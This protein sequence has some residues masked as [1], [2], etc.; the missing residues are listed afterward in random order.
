MR[1]RPLSPRLHYPRTRLSA[2][3]AASVL[4]VAC[5]SGALA[6][7]GASTDM[8][9][10]GFGTAAPYGQSSVPARVSVVYAFTISGKVAGLYPGKTLPLVLVVKNLRPFE[11]TVESIT[12]TVG[13]ARP[14]C[15]AKNLKVTTFVGHLRVQPKKSAKTT[16]KVTLLHAA[17][18]GCEKAVFPFTY[19]GQATAP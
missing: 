2:W 18:N 19:H 8:R 17:P 6:L 10:V 1:I 16:V 4:L 9:L 12:T 15:T 13:K 5:A 14:A 11:I 7:G 3:I